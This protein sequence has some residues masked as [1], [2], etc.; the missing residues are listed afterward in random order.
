MEDQARLLAVGDHI[1]ARRHLV[2][3]RRE[4]D[5][6]LELGDVRRPEAL[7]LRRG[8]LQAT[9]ARGQLP[10]T[11]MR[12]GR[13]CTALATVAAAVPPTSL[14]G[15]LRTP[16]CRTVGQGLRATAAPVS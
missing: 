14:L 13:S 10:L 8:K 1:Q 3:H 15:G 2:V 6:L 5:V 12:R 16:I 9:P 4:H 7:Q 11:V